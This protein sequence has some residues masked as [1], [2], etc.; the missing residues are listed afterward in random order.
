M[1]NRAEQALVKLAL[2]PEWEARFEPNSYGF[3]PGRSAHDAIEAIFKS[4][5]HQSKF[6][7]DADLR[8]CFDKMSHQAILRK[9]QTFST[10]R[11]TI[12]AWLK[13]GVIEDNQLFPTTEGSPQ[14]GVISP[15]I[16]NIALHG[17][18]TTVTSKYPKAK[19][20]RY[21]DDMV[22]I[23]PDEQ[24]IKQIQ[25]RVAEW[26]N[27]IGLELNLNKTRTVH[28]LNPT[29]EPAGF[30]FLGFNIRQ[31]PVGKT[32]SKQHR[33]T[34]QPG[35]KTIIKPSHKATQR[36][37][38]KLRHVIKT[39][40]MIDQARLIGQ[41]NPIIK[42]WTNY[43]AT[44]V[45]KKTFT[46]LDSMTYI[47]LMRWAKRRHQTKTRQWIT[48]KYWRLEQG[49]WIFASPGGFPLLR[50]SQTPCKRHVKVQG[51]RSP[52]DGDWSYW[53]LRKARH[54]GIPKRITFLLRRQAGRCN[55]CG[56]YFRTEDQ[57][58][59][60]HILPKSQGGQDAYNN[61]QLLHTHCHH[62]KSAAEAKTNRGANNHSQSSEEPCEANVSRTVLKPSGR[63]DP[64]T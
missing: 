29:T 59:V 48:H 25:H 7:L 41:L 56:L 37:L 1:R 49:K 8:K 28:S 50:H 53:G 12:R 20:V 54:P 43:Y 6:V 33:K 36:H 63:G 52:Y 62:Q 30:D 27:D 34:N 44:V 38:Q 15:L 4:L 57:L 35:F 45:S 24:V 31:Y 47:K 61:W 23:H 13:A 32:H 60:D 9:L 19:V 26:L 2:E 3:R 46:K 39:S 11:R 16:S 64:A 51:S 14:G 55:F 10:M 58:E 40:S 22:V 18:E 5:C 21:A 17:L 42:G